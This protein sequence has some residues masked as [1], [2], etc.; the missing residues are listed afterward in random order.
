M[1]TMKL[2]RAGSVFILTLTNGELA[3]T[4]TTDVADEYNAALDELEA[5]KGNAALVLTSSDIKFWCN[6]IN[7]RWLLA[8]PP[9]CFPKLAA[10]LDRMFLRLA[11]LNMPT[12]G[13][14]TGHTYAGGAV[15]AS[16]LD[17]RIMRED[18]GFFCFSEVDVKV[19]FTPV[20]HE[21]IGSLA[22]PPTLRELLLTGRRLTGPEAL[23]AKVVSAVYPGEDLL[24]KTMELA[25][26]LSQKDRET[27][28]SIKRGM[29]RR[30][31]KLQKNLHK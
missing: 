3:N 8:Q 2:K 4:I 30:L 16:T 9:D 11:L 6:G 12:V 24:P 17:F 29:R 13:C 28:T 1:A 10:M 23:A 21:M 22:D 31:V 20:M 18:R 25:E 19:P 14:L 5:A 27:Y 15:M 7:L 26:A